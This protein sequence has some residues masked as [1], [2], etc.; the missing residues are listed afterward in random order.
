MA[1]SPVNDSPKTSFSTVSPCAM[2]DAE[3]VISS[4]HPCSSSQNT[5][6]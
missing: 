5:S 1:G 3:R 4:L 2:P 6:P